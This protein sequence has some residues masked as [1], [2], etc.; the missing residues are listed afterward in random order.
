MIHWM[1]R[2]VSHVSSGWHLFVVI[3][4]I[5][6]LV[7]MGWLL[8]ANRKATARTDSDG[9]TGHDYGGIQEL[10]NPLPAWWLGLFVVSMLFAVGYLVVYPGLGNVAGVAEWSSETQW[11]RESD[12]YAA[13]FE[14]FYLALAERDFESLAKDGRAMQVGR[15]L[16]LN[17]C[18]TCHGSAAKGSTGYPDLTDA[19]WLWGGSFT[20]IKTTI[21][22]GRVA[23][24]P[25]WLPALGE[26]GVADT[27][28]YVL[29]LSGRTVDA[30]TA[31]RGAVHYQTFCV[32]CHGADGRG[33]VL[34]GA[35]DMTNDIWLYGG[36]P[37]AVSESIASGRFGN[38]PAHG[39]LLGDNRSHVLAAYI[40]Q[41]GSSE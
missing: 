3:G 40:A 12:A 25:G 34:F 2:K 9:T 24:M 33:N 23:A 17:N 1:H 38:M 41:L 4:T 14:P 20:A 8:F 22:G 7:V 10:D 30:D 11:Q 5:G 15:R 19:E 37:D 31:A 27:A 6:S 29:E 28:A 21:A 16:F 36:E 35:P 18:A 39:A 13:R 26:T 32:A